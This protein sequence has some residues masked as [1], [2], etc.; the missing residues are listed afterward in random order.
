LAATVG[1]SFLIWTHAA[2]ISRSRLLACFTPQWPN[3]KIAVA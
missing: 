2:R 3:L 1:H